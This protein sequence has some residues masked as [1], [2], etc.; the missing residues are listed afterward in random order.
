MSASAVAIADMPL[1]GLDRLGSCFVVSPQPERM[2]TYAPFTGKPIADLPLSTTSDVERAMSAARAAQ[3]T[4]AERGVADRARVV[5]RFHDLL[6]QRQHEILD[7]VQLESGKA[8]AHAFEELGGVVAH[9]RIVARRALG[10][11]RARRRA[12]AIP[13]LTRTVEHHHPKGVVG[14]ISPWNY[15]LVLGAND[16][17]AALLAGNAV[18]QKPDSQTPLSTAWVVDLMM[19]AGLPERL[20]QLVLGDGPVIGGAIVDNADYLC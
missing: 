14:V 2:T 1:M 3:P 13:V 8:R 15:P 4:W 20:W 10:H 7:L 11:L 16:A 18:V 17:V 5:L 12:G 9:A 19:E 6:L